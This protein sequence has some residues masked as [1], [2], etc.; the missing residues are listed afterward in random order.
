MTDNTQDLNDWA[1]PLP[2]TQIARRTAQEF[3]NMQPTSQKAEQVRLKTLAVYVINDYLQMLNVPTNLTVSDSWNPIM[4]LC[5]DVADLEIVG[6]GRLECRP[7][8]PQAE[9]CH[10]PP[11]VW[12][13]RIG[14][15]AVEIDEAA[16][17]ASVLGFSQTA[18]SE[19]L[20]SELLPIEDL[21]DCLNQ[22]LAPTTTIPVIQRSTVNLSKWLVNVFESSWQTVES[23]LNPEELTPAFRSKSADNTIIT[24]NE[25]L[26]T[27]SRAK[28]IDLGIQ[29]ANQPFALIVDFTSD[30]AKKD[31][32][33]QIHPSGNQIYLP[34]AL[35]LIVLDE[36]GVVFLEAQARSADNY[37]QL[38]FSGLPGEKF[39]VKVALGE[40]S[41]TEDFVI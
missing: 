9:T 8:K 27:I 33:L 6:I 37:I 11:E 32:R 3:A 14:Y 22:P 21:I 18:K 7:L 15:V 40:A 23:L 25:N 30:A 2:I 5:A 35:Q 16:G 10:V 1:L 17:E 28:L 26:P 13:D 38:Q 19:L 41:I 29:I 4:R 12:S 31:I 39:T 24:D 20:K 34:P 36:T